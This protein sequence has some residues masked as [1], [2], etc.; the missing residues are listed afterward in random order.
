M[1]L[2]IEGV[3]VL[4]FDFFRCP[5]QSL[6]NWSRSLLAKKYSVDAKQNLKDSRS[7]SRSLGVVVHHYAPYG[8]EYKKKLCGRTYDVGVN[9][10]L[11]DLN[12]SN[13]SCICY[14]A[15]SSENYFEELVDAFPY[16]SFVKASGKHYDFGSFF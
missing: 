2:I 15:D 5:V 1:R 7:P 9:Y 10:I 8:R 4:F 6:A 14:V 11:E 3:L 13:Y 16:I 12:R